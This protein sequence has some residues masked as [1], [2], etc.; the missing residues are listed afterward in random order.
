MAWRGM[1][2]TDPTLEYTAGRGVLQ[3]EARI[4]R[5]ILGVERIDAVA[6]IDFAGGTD[7]SEPHPEHVRDDGDAVILPW[8]TTPVSV[9]A[10][11][12]RVIGVGVTH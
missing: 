8:E 11:E 1:L 4:A 2:A 6:S 12:I 7:L 5:A 10:W 9:R 3:I